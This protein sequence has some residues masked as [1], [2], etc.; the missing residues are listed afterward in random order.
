MASLS[1]PFAN[2]DFGDLPAV[3]TYAARDGVKLGYRVYE[4]GAAQV[5]VLM[6]GSYD[7]GVAMHPLAKAL[8]DACATVYVP[9][10][11]GPRDAG[12]GGVGAKSP[13]A[14][15]TLRLPPKRGCTVSYFARPK[16]LIDIQGAATIG[17]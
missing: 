16:M 9:V 5:V 3:Q 2:V 10:V 6:H 11:G 12:R 14:R 15:I 4:G 7:D 1:A 8:R 17:G 13:L